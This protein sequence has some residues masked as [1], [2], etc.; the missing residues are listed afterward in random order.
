MT[1]PQLCFG[2]MMIIGV[3]TIFYYFLI[4]YF[5]QKYNHLFNT[6]HRNSTWV[7]NLQSSITPPH[8]TFFGSF[9]GK[10]FYIEGEPEPQYLIKYQQKSLTKKV[11]TKNNQVSNITKFNSTKKSKCTIKNGSI[12][13][14]NIL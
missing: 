9:N 13:H 8:A 6:T 7:N 14:K 2:I 10:E 4:I 12:K 3:F 11:N 1:G 5:D